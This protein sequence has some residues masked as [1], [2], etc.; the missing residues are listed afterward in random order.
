MK[1]T[2]LGT[3]AAY[4]GTSEACTGFLLQTAGLNIVIDMGTG[5]LGNL[6][7]HIDLRDVNAILISHM[8]ADHF[9]DLIPYR[10]ALQYG[11]DYDIS[12]GKIDLFLPPEGRKT[13]N[14]VVS[15]YSES[16]TFFED[17]FTMHEY[18]PNNPIMYHDIWLEFIPVQHFIPC[19]GLILKSEGKI[20]SYSSDTGP[21]ESLDE[22]AKDADFF[23]CHAG[24]CLI[25]GKV[26]EYGHMA[27]S[28][29]GEIARKSGTKR[30]I[31]SH[32]WPECDEQTTISA[33]SAT[34]G[35]DVELAR[36]SKTYDL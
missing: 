32:L 6:Q 20:I 4:P 12:R 2:V 30:L 27:P 24:A 31:L 14:T 18:V 3:S 23:I 11:L 21:C 35:K 28:I 1:I 16:E 36:S 34:F 10:Y 26:S 17:V 7:K 13:L 29:A 15:P 19:Y 5:T 9:F 22:I 8:H 33:A 25:N